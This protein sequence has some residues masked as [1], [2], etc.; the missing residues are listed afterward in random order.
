MRKRHQAGLVL[1]QQRTR[2]EQRTVQ[3]PV[4]IGG[5]FSTSD[6]AIY[7]RRPDGSIRKRKARSK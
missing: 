7:Q 2:A 6:G 4:E 1:R 5:A 3:R